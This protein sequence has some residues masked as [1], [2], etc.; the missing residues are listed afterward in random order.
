M[1][2]SLAFLI[3]AAGPRRKLLVVPADPFK[4]PAILNGAIVI[5]VHLIP[6]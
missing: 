5:P 6:A 1:G 3:L 2:I 4:L